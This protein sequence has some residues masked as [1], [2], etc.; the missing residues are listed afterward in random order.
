MLKKLAFLLILF[1]I[2]VLACSS[3][4][5]NKSKYN[6]PADHQISKSGAMHKSG[7]SNPQANCTSCHGENLQGGSVGVSCYSCH[8]RKW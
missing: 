1:F 4:T 2:F 8:G 3:P 5:G 6:P 7:L